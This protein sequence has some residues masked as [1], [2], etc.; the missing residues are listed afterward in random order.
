[1]NRCAGAAAFNRGA[2]TLRRGGA[3]A[4]ARRV[5]CDGARPALGRRTSWPARARRPS[6]VTAFF[7]AVFGAAFGAPSS[8]APSRDWRRRAAFFLHG[9]LRFRLLAFGAAFLDAAFFPAPL[10]PL[11]VLAMSI[12]PVTT[13]SSTRL[14][15][16]C[17]HV[18]Q[19]APTKLIAE[20]LPVRATTPMGVGTPVAGSIRNPVMSS[21]SWF[22]A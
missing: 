13:L 22:A 14:S 1:M 7:I 9:G 12:P 15:A 11:T 4:R 17:H 2:A 19:E 21:L 8:R 5:G 16:R 6:S 20:G 3:A 18:I 10:R